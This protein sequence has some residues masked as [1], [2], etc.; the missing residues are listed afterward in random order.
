VL[1]VA[2]MYHYYQPYGIHT[3]VTYGDMLI[4]I[5]KK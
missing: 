4:E 3:E 5:Y 2:H 1:E